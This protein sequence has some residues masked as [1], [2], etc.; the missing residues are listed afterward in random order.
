[1]KS[2][3]KIII[4]TFLVTSVLYITIW[5]STAGFGINSSSVN[6]KI[7]EIKNLIDKN[8]IMEFDED[9]AEFNALYSYVRTLEDNYATYFEPEEYADYIDEGKGNFTGIGLYVQAQSGN[10]ADGIFINRVIGN[11]P[12]EKAGVK[13]NDVI[14]KI[15]E[16][17]V[18][19]VEY[20]KAV[21]MLLGLE[22]SLVDITVRRG[23]TGEVLVYTV[24]RERFTQREVD[25]RVIENDIGFI[26]IHDFNTIASS[27][28]E[29]ALN[30]L[31]KQDVKG[32]IFDVR[33]NL[34]GELN[35]VKSMIDLLIPEDELV[36]LKYKDNEIV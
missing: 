1:M 6:N 34:G 15:G 22:D 14:I 12:A 35:T 27:E 18:D 8:A 11:S 26:R 24:K 7:I 9:E 10:I 17:T 4:S 32:F 30:E 28:F 16:T 29:N 36:V 21:E 3:L 20:Q 31:L 2:K 25:F 5:S 33:N 19:G 23:D 13:A